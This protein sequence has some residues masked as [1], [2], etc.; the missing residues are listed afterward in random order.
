ML[1]LGENNAFI[2]YLFA[3]V[4]PQIWYNWESPSSTQWTTV[5]FPLSSSSVA[6]G[7]GKFISA[8]GQELAYTTDGLSWTKISTEKM[9]TDI[10]YSGGKFIGTGSSYIDCS[11][12]GLT[13]TVNKIKTTIP[14]IRSVVS[15]DN[16][17]FVAVGYNSD[18]NDKAAYSIDGGETWSEVI[19]PSPAKWCGITYGDGKF[20]A[21]ANDSDKVAYSTDGIN[22]N[23]TTLP[24]DSGLKDI[25]YGNGK[26]VVVSGGLLKTLVSDDG[27]NW[28][29][30]ITNISATGWGGLSYGDGRFVM[31]L[32]YQKY[33]AYSFDGSNWFLEV[34]PKVGGWNASAYGN[35]RFVITS[36][37]TKDSACLIFTN[38]KSYFTSVENPTIDSIVYSAPNT[39]SSLT[40][41]SIGTGTITLDDK[42][43]YT[44]NPSGNIIGH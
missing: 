18:D 15:N 16:G 28:E 9:F 39:P 10:F 14:F 5:S 23:Q 43:V 22:W 13:W 25:A 35:G 40:I 38:G 4:K 11:L 1:I 33:A 36:K 34:T 21:V 27:I 20:V 3:G 8:D 41:T 44:Y 7:D 31:S 12:D 6:Y 42:N 2:P 32:Y 24:A 37:V 26:F 29:F 19:L 17:T 30:G